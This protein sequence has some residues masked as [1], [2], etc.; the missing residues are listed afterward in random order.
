MRRAQEDNISDQLLKKLEEHLR[1][2]ER[3]LEKRNPGKDNDPDLTET[4]FTFF[5]N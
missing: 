1:E 5:K 2:A 3:D 4:I